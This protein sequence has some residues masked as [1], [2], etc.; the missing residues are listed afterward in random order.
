MLINENI[1]NAI[2]IYLGYF[3]VFSV[4]LNE[5]VS[6]G[7][8]IHAHAHMMNRNAIREVYKFKSIIRISYF[9]LHRYYLAF[10]RVLYEINRMFQ[11]L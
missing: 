7:R 9:F 4:Y 6:K 2:V 10:L 5:R 3:P 8:Y 11:K 1:K